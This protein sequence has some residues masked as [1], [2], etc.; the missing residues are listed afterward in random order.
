MKQLKFVENRI[1]T[2]KIKMAILS[3][4]KTFIERDERCVKQK[5]MNQK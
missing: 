5:P 3:K 4:E 1:F 2:K